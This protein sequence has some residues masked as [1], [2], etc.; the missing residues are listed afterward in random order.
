[1]QK[2]TIEKNPKKI[3]IAK[4]EENQKKSL[5][6]WACAKFFWKLI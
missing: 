4:L 3:L 6:Q 5:K 1:M 2:T